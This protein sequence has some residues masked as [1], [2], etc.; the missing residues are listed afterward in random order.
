[1]VLSLNA[2]AKITNNGPA[3]GDVPGGHVPKAAVSAK[4]HW[5][6]GGCKPKCYHNVMPFAAALLPSFLVFQPVLLPSA[7]HSSL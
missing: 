7:A 3:S 4:H 2:M 6:V 1:M 5:P